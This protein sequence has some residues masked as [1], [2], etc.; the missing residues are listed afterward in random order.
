MNSETVLILGWIDLMERT[1]E[2]ST[3]PVAA[4]VVP[5]AE[6][7]AAPIA[8]AEPTPIPALAAP[9]DPNE[10][11]AVQLLQFLD[12]WQREHGQMP[13]YNEIAKQ[14]LNSNNPG[15]AH[16]CVRAL[17]EA[18][19]VVKEPHVHRGIRITP[20]GREVLADCAVA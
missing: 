14:H 2:R 13:S 1:V 18:G 20:E 6:P 16:Y 5:A 7:V 10:Q 9:P 3:V 15:L 12:R 19:L 11:P 8:L 4:A 17:E